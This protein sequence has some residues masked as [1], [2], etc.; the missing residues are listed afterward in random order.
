L[1]NYNIK[2]RDYRSLYP[3]HASWIFNDFA[4]KVDSNYAKEIKSLKEWKNRIQIDIFN[5]IKNK[6]KDIVGI[7]KS[8]HDKSIQILTDLTNGFAEKVLME[9]KDNLLKLRTIKR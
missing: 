4:A 5:T 8:K 9:T 7:Y 2:E 1:R 3:D 6:E